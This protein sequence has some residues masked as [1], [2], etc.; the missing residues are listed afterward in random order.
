M[1]LPYK[2]K[3]IELFNNGKLTTDAAEWYRKKGYVLVCNDGKVT[4]IVCEEVL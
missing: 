4:N 2:D 3:I 1:E